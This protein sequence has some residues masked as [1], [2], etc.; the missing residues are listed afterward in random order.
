MSVTIKDIARET[1]LSNATISAYLNGIPVRKYNHVKIEEAIKRLGYIRND[2]ARGLKTHCSRT[3]GVLIPE[4]SNV[5]STT[6]ITELEEALRDKGYGII[7]CDCRSDLQREAEALKFLISKMVDGLIIMPVSTR[8]EAL[9]SALE[10]NIP[11]VIIDR[12]TNAETVSH[13]VINNREVSVEATERLLE[14]GCSTIALIVGDDSVYTARERRLGY[15][16]AMKKRG[17]YD[18]SCVYDGG[19]SVQG[20]Y[21]ATKQILSD[22]PDVQGIFVANYEMT[23]GSMIALNE[24]G[25][26]IGQDIHFMGFDNIEISKAFVPEIETVTQPLE[27][28]GRCAAEKLLDIIGGG[29]PCNIILKATVI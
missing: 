23:I 10:K 27:E 13:V 29:G 9:A 3:V 1:G 25:K 28:I 7:V 22:H 12:M 20:G 24:E 18:E 19:L 5:F 6:I 16:A 26:R 15:R 11:M 14:K 21:A 2:Y 17:L 4:L 8:K